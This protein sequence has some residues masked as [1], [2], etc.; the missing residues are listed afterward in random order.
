MIK[1][2]IFENYRKKYN[3]SKTKNIYFLILSKKDLTI[4]SYYE[5]H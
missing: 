3:F 1:K 2:I 4:K 5:K